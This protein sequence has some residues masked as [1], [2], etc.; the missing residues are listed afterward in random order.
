MGSWFSNLNVRKTTTVDVE[1]LCAY[2]T[3]KM[4]AQQYMPAS[5]SEADCGFAVFTVQDSQWIT[6]CTDAFSLEEPHSFSKIG[7]PLSSELGTDVL[8]ISCFDSDFLFLTILNAAEGLD[9]WASVG[10]IAELGAE[11]CNNLS[12]WK[13]KVSDFPRFQAALAR[14][15]VFAEEV[16]TEIEDCLCLSKI[17]SSSSLEY[18]SETNAANTAVY[19]Y[20]K[21]QTET[22]HRELPKLVQ[23]SFSLTPCFLGKPSIVTVNNVGGESKGMSV[24]FTGPYVEHEEI[25]FPEVGFVRDRGGKMEWLPFALKKIRLTDGQWAYYYHDPRLLL[26]PKVDKRLPPM[27]YYR[28]SQERSVTVRF[29]PRGNARKLLDITVVLVP[30]ENPEGQ[31]AWNAWHQFGSKAAFLAEYNQTRQQYPNAKT[32]MLR[33]EDFD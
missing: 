5:K 28:A 18:L 10:N 30:D 3:N 14:Q 2:I 25:T 8:G 27:Q 1:R 9:A 22:V 13:N 7:T 26:P 20:F 33:E 31:S 29:V 32:E 19:M 6:V 16:L 21:L 11:G 4:V 17:Q 15:Y 24:Y 23:E 12:A